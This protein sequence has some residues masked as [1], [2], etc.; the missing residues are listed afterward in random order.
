M[1]QKELGENQ[2]LRRVTVDSHIFQSEQNKDFGERFEKDIDLQVE[3]DFSN[4]RWEK[5]PAK[6]H[7]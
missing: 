5:C 6:K 1:I 2:E 7:I 3:E 4:F